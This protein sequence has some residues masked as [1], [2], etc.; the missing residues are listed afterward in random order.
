MDIYIRRDAVEDL[1]EQASGVWEH[2]SPDNF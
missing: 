1:E 2:A